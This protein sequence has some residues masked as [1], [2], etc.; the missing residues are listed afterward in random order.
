MNLAELLVAAGQF[1]DGENL[2]RQALDSFS[3][4]VLEFP[5]NLGYVRDVAECRRRMTGS[6]VAEPSSNER[7]AESQLE[8]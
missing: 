5:A 8:K 6:S 1:Q 7:N 3:R 2:Y 4:L